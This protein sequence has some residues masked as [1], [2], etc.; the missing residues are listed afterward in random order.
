M[1]KPR[2]LAEHDARVGENRL[3]SGDLGDRV[4][5]PVQATA[6]SLT[7]HPKRFAAPKWRQDAGRHTG[8]NTGPSWLHLL[9]PFHPAINLMSIPNQ[10]NEHD[11]SATRRR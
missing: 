4:Q 8:K 6:F 9:K 2:H 3:Q 5:L 1:C 10:L 7:V 11:Y